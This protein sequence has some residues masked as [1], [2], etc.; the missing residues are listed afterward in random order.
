[1][2]QQPGEVHIAEPLPWNYPI[3]G[4]EIVAD[5]AD[6]RVYVL[7]L[8]AGPCVPWHYHSE[9]TDRF[10]RLKRSVVSRRARRR[11]CMS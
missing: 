7:T 9:A 10:V 4:R 5:G 8:D 1:M 6:L 2:K 11:Q 3:A